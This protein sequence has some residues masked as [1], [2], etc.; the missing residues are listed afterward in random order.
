MA[1]ESQEWWEWAS[2]LII[3]LPF[4]VIWIRDYL[5]DFNRRKRK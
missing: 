2:L 5:D 1:K 3:L 4:I